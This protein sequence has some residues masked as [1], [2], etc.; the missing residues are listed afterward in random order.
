MDW[1]LQRLFEPTDHQLRQ[2]ESGF[3]FIYDGIKSSD[4]ERVMSEQFHRLDSIMFTGIIIT[5]ED[6]EP[7]L[8][9]V[10][11]LAMREDD[12]C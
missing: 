6:G 12:G 5:D 2:E 4:I 7:V 10:T 3:V 9:P 8:D 11:G 1:Q